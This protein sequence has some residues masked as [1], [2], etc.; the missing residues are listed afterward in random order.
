[1]ARWGWLA[2]GLL[3]GC[4]GGGGGDDAS[5]PVG[6]RIVAAEGGA[7]TSADGI[8]TM[9]VPAG[10]LAEDTTFT[11]ARL[12][13]GD[14]PSD[15]LDGA[16]RVEPSGTV[17]AIPAVAVFAYAAS[18]P[19]G[20]AAVSIRVRSG[21]AIEEPAVAATITSS[22][23]ST[24]ALAEVEH[25]SDF[26]LTMSGNAII[27]RLG[28][29]QAYVGVPYRDVLEGAEW[30]ND[31]D[32][33]ARY[34]W[35]A[36]TSAPAILAVTGP[37][38]WTSVEDLFP[39]ISQDALRRYREHHAMDLPAASGRYGPATEV[40]PGARG[41]AVGEAEWTC[42]APGRAVEVTAHFDARDATGSL[43]MLIYLRDVDCVEPPALP[44]GEARV[45]S[46]QPVELVGETFYL[47]GPE[48]IEVDL[49]AY[50]DSILT[51][52]TP[53]G[54]GGYFYDASVEPRTRE[55]SPPEVRITTSEQDITCTLT[56]GT[57][58]ST[59][60]D[61]SRPLFAPV[62]TATWSAGGSEV[63]TP[64]PANRISILDEITITP[65]PPGGTA[66]DVAVSFPDGIADYYFARATLRDRSSG[67]TSRLLYATLTTAFG[68]NGTNREGGLIGADSFPEL[69]AR[70]LTF[71]GEIDIGFANRAEDATIFPVSEGMIFW[72]ARMLRVRFE[73]LVP[74]PPGSA[75]TAD[76]D[77][78][79]ATLGPLD[80]GGTDPRVAVVCVDD[81]DGFCFVSNDVGEDTPLGAA[82]CAAPDRA[83][84]LEPDRMTGE[85]DACRIDDGWRPIWSSRGLDAAR[86]C[87]ETGGAIGEPHFFE[88]ERIAD[89]ARRRVHFRA[90]GPGTVEVLSVERDPTGPYPPFAAQHSCREMPL[91]FPPSS[92]RGRPH[93][94]IDFDNTDRCAPC[95]ITGDWVATPEVETSCPDVGQL[96]LYYFAATGD[97]MA[98]FTT[99]L[100]SEFWRVESASAGTLVPPRE[101]R[102]FP[103]DTD[104]TLVVTDGSVRWQVVFRH[105]SADTYVV[106]SIV[107]L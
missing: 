37:T 74:P 49:I 2:I 22:D 36:G 100:M 46:V 103:A 9:I 43:L 5:L 107:Q 24:H 99:A 102:D 42:L 68:F 30:L 1:M 48:T 62:D 58:E 101:V 75:T 63:T 79:P 78:L 41:R 69:E 90:T 65:A 57:Y 40:A 60:I 18:P 15:A 28:E 80:P 82:Q 72:A 98:R 51:E 81:A 92:S 3:V 95:L 77:A 14:V 97:R 44:A 20:D 104:V 12:A 7:V 56:D 31:S 96:E 64:A 67:V 83:L 21:A 33:P 38:E 93:A 52:L 50:E 86:H 34:W 53:L 10:A 59:G 45:A 8:F 4:D 27:A 105:T 73:D 35:G 70:G 6:T 26:W 55:G 76:C 106:S 71:T 19:F 47:S 11:V 66:A 32:A 29:R 54:D 17:F 25:L 61:L 16:Y 39:V 94:S 13:G 91:T 85:P 87:M 23:G 89:G 84:I 88:V